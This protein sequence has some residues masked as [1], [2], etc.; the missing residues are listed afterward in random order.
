MVLGRGHRGSS[1]HPPRCGGARSNK[2]LDQALLDASFDGLDEA[3]GV[4]D[5][6]DAVELAGLVAGGR[7]ETGDDAGGGDAVTVAGGGPVVATFILDLFAAHPVPGAEPAG[8][9]VEGALQLAPKETVA[10]DLGVFGKDAV[11]R[12]GGGLAGVDVLEEQGPAPVVDVVF[13]L[14][15]GVAA[16]FGPLLRGELEGVEFTDGEP[17]PGEGAP[18]TPGEVTRSGLVGLAE[19]RGQIVDESPVMLDGL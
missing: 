5:E 18:V 6:A 9:A 2:R 13:E 15:A 7:A 10:E 16:D 12:A 11:L 14:F 19:V 1:S 8:A 4:A 3:C 17:G